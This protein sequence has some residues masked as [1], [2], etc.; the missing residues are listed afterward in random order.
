MGE[1]KRREQAGTGPMR[2]KGKFQLETVFVSGEAYV[3]EADTSGWFSEKADPVLIT[4]DDRI[5]AFYK[6]KMKAI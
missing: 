6:A 3:R 4:V 5:V 1:A 2:V